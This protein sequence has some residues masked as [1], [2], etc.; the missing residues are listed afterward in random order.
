MSFVSVDNIFQSYDGRPVLERVSLEAEE[1]AFVSIVGASGCGKSTFLR[2]LLA[3]EQPT[4]G[5]IRIDGAPPAREPDR[6]R[7]V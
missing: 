7:G 1:G 4:R 2:L 5:T 3:Q 6:A